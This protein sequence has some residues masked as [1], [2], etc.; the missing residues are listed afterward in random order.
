MMI[1]R[2]VD[3]M[4]VIRKPGRPESR[5]RTRM[6]LVLR[7][8]F[9]YT[10]R[11]MIQDTRKAD[12]PLCKVATVENPNAG[13]RVEYFSGLVDASVEIG[14]FL[15]GRPW[16]PWCPAPSRA[17]ARASRRAGGRAGACRR[18]PGGEVRRTAAVR[19]GGGHDRPHRQPDPEAP[20]TGHPRRHRQQCPCLP[21]QFG[22]SARRR[23]D[24]LALSGMPPARMER[25]RNSLMDEL[26]RLQ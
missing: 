3:H 5:E 20:G 26:S 2:D 1:T 6:K 24:G 4:T 25:R 16:P 15:A 7:R 14:G 18:P 21:P 22:L 9:I 11:K 19:D 10:E 23:S 17:T 8:W 12:P 13:K